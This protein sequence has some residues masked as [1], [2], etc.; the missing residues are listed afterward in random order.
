[1]EIYQNILT[2]ALLLA[3]SEMEKLEKA[4]GYYGDS[5]ALATTRLALEAVKKGQSL[6]VK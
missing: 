6:Y 2:N 5:A 4:Q 1:M 3:I